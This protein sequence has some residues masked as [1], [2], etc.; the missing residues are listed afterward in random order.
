[1]SLYQ[2]YRPKTLDE[3][4]GN[5]STIKGLVEHFNQPKARVSH[6]HIIHGSSGCGKTTLARAIARSILGANDL[7]IHEIN[8]ASNRGVD[9]A[10]E[11]IEKM[12]LLPLG[13]GSVVY[14]IDEAH[15]M[16]T[17]AKRAFLKPLEDCPAHCYFFLCTTNLP[18]LLKGDEGKAIGTRCTQWKVEPLNSRQVGQLVDR[19]AKAEEYEVDDEL[20]AAIIDNA[21]G[22]PRAALVAL[23]KVM[24]IKD[25]EDQLKVLEASLEDDPDIID[26]CR[27]LV[28][29]KASWPQ[30]ADQLKQLKTSQ[31]P[32]AI[33]RCVLGFAQACLLKRYDPAVAQVLEAFEPATYD[34]GFPGIVLACARSRQW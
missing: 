33:R 15:G 25:R 3:M 7:T 27:L 26:L 12:K 32:E 6:A 21:D 14:I 34:I 31:E 20:M 8:S 18:Q 28:N 17:D 23:E 1:M 11:I 19:V 2:N 29:S 10:R 30:V 4:V 22:S 16:T 13:G 5:S 9:T 24:S